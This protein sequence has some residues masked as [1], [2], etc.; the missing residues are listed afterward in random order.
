V[1]RETVGRETVRREAVPAQ[2]RIAGGCEVLLRALTPGG[3]RARYQRE[4]CGRQDLEDTRTHH[5]YRSFVN[6]LR[7]IQA[8]TLQSPC[9]CRR[10]APSSLQDLPRIAQERAAML[11]AE[12]DA[13]S[14]LIGERDPR[15]RLEVTPGASRS[16]ALPA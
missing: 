11:S 15:A 3:I 5:D 6:T 10:G 13:S 1:G 2:Y 12:G 8:F 14:V 9:Q 4:R 16:D 7:T